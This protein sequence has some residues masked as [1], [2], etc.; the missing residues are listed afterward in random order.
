MKCVKLSISLFGL[1]SFVSADAYT[2]RLKTSTIGAINQI[3]KMGEDTTDTSV[4]DS[5]AEMTDLYGHRMTGHVQYD[6][7]ADW[8]VRDASM[9]KNFV[10]MREPATVNVWKRNT[11]SATLYIPTRSPPE[12][13]LPMLGLGQSIGTGP[14][15]I[16]A[17]VIPVKTFEDLDKLGNKTVAGKL[18]L[19]CDDWINYSS[20]SKYRTMG[21]QNAEK[22]GAVG[23]LVQSITGYSLVTPHTGVMNP[24]KIP[25]AAISVEDSKL[26]Q[27]MYARYNAVQ[28]DPKI[29]NS[30][31]FVMPRVK[32]VMNAENFENSTI[33]Y[34]IV[35]D[36][37]GSEN[38]EEIVVIS[39]HFDSWDVGVGAMDDGGGAFT[40]YGALKIIS[41]LTTRPKRTIRVVM[42]NNEEY[43]SRGAKAYF[44]AHKNEVNKHVFAMESDSGN[45]EPWGMSVMAD[46]ATVAKLDA[47]GKAFFPKFGGG[48]TQVKT[49]PNVDITPLCNA[50]VPCGG[51]NSLDKYTQMAPYEVTGREGYFRFHHTDADRMEVLDR[52]QLRRNAVSMAT[53]A[54]LLADD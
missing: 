10:V 40:S 2:E 31:E 45:F 25:G 50:G 42:W 26:I 7:S 36:L 13:N 24:S 37:K 51:F 35:I 43:L 33:S 44:E 11:E 20:N 4:W 49:S 52:H 14:K 3:S 17:D 29:P 28:K 48:I 21:A 16:E 8:V 9:N 54:Y 18:V 41:K 1:L 39:G 38:P 34:N 32:L 19:L 27:R 15:G 53:W 22:Y 46:N 30:K 12:V 23:V 6:R 5:L 47:Y